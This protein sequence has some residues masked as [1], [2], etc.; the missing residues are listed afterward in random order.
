MKAA[1]MLVLAAALSGAGCT[2]PANGPAGVDTLRGRTAV[3]G[4]APMNTRVSLQVEDGRSIVLTGPLSTELGR[5]AGAELEVVGRM[6]GSEMEPTAYRVVSVDGRPALVGV[7]ES[8]PG[9]GLQLRTDD[10]RTVRLGGGTADLRPGQKV[11]VQ[12]PDQL[13]VQTFGVIVP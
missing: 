7:V 4:S 5:L 6:A 12:G 13:Q 3:V 10:G 2:P 1:V 9:G 8:A 11:W